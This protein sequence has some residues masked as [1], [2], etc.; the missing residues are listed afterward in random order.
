M[1]PLIHKG[2]AQCTKY[3]QTA[4]SYQ[5]KTFNEG[6]GRR[7]CLLYHW[8]IIFEIRLDIIRLDIFV[9]KDRII[10]RPS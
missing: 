10:D 9:D 2:S 4:S 1:P 3:V 5:Q 6:S 7:M 8:Y